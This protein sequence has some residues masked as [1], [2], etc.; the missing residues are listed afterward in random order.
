MKKHLVILALITTPFWGFSQ[1]ADTLII[2]LDSL[3]RKTDSV[4]GQLNYTDPHAYDANTRINFNSYLTLLGSDL[5]QQFTKPFHMTGKDWR[6]FGKFVI[7]EGALAFA[8]EPVQ[9]NVAP[10]KTKNPAIGNA[11]KFVTNF[12]GTYEAFALAA[13]RAYGLVSKNEKMKTTTL[14]ATQAYITGTALTTVLKYITGRTR[15]SLY[16]LYE[17]AEPQFYGPFPKN[18]N[19]LS[20]RDAYSSFPSGH[21]TVAFAA[22]TVFALEYSNKPWVPIIAYSSATLI[23]LSRMTENKHWATDVFAGAAIGFLAGKNVV[24]NYHRYAKLKA[25]GLRKNHPVSFSLHYNSGHLEPGLTYR[26]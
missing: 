6:N 14:L 7:I 12:G 2:K 15:P 22:A 13:F 19:N 26:L 11:S 9:K 23:G 10:I 18:V 16:G 1:K 3:S 20:V 5:K 24:N 21:T 4:G 8:D 17:D 25:S